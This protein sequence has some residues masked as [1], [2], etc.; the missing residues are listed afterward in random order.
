MV[1]ISKQQERRRQSPKAPRIGGLK[2]GPK[3]DNLPQ[4]FK[5]HDNAVGGDLAQTHFISKIK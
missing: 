2:S 4:G 1:R 3:Q 5:L